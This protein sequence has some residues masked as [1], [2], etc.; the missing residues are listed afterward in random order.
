M[1]RPLLRILQR[2]LPIPCSAS[3]PGS[4]IVNVIRIH[5]QKT[6]KLIVGEFTY[7][8]ANIFFE[9]P[10]SIVSIG[11]RTFI[12][13]S[14][15]ASATG[16]YIGSDV[17]ISW[18][19]TIVDHDSHALDYVDRSHDAMEWLQGRKD[20]SRVPTAP[21]TVA[22]KVWIGFG[23]SIL[24]GITVG[25]GAVVGAQSVVTRDVAPWTVVAGNPARAI[26][27]LDPGFQNYS[28]QS[29]VIGSEKH[30]D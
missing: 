17:L 15:L 7:V 23:A 20:W 28:L 24:K 25:E 9:R 13:R 8:D 21:V 30:P 18:G 1:K 6:N 14:L 4:S 12:G 3:L 19:V 29:A 10:S 22:D 2:V 5:G 27:Q 26:R 16:I 11:S